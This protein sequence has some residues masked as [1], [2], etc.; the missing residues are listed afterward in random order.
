MIT[1]VRGTGSV[2]LVEFA[3]Y[4]C[5][6]CARHAKETAPTIK[7]ELLDSGQIQHVFFNFPLAIHAHAQKAGEAAECAARQGRFWEMHERLF[8]DTSALADTDLIAKAAAIGL[9][10]TKF[11]ECLT[12][13]A[14][15]SDVRADLDEGRRLGV[16]STPSFFVGVRQ[17]DGT[18]SL[19]RRIS[20]AV[21]FATLSEAIQAAAV[22]QRARL[23]QP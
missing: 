13:G 23:T 11:R 20:G 16:N 1:H 9:D 6:F 19:L 12:S 2:A 10:V 4:E 17:P 22:S 7:E 21:P 14:T 3:D 5:P 15:A 18:I 8:E